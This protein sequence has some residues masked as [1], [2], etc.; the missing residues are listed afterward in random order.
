MKR[1]S[2]LAAVAVAAVGLLA[3]KAVLAQTGYKFKVVT[4][5]KEYGG[6]QFQI[7]DL[8]NKDQFSW[9]IVGP[10]KDSGGGGEVTYFWDGST[11]TRIQPSDTKLSD[12]AALI[13]GNMW[14]PQGINDAGKVAYV[15]DTDKS[16]HAIVVWDSATKT[17]TMI[18]NID[19]VVEGG[20]LTS[21]GVALEGRMVAEINNSDQV[22]W[23]EGLDSGNGDPNDAVFLFDPATK[24]ITTVAHNGTALPGGKTI[25]NALFPNINDAGEVVFMANTTDNENF[26]VYQWAAGNITVICAPDTT[27]DGVK[28]ASAKLPR[29]ANGGLV[30]F[31]GETTPSGSGAPQATD[32]GF[33][34]F[35]GGKLTKVVAPGDALPGGKFVATEGNRRAVGIN[36]DGLVAFKAT[37]ENDQTGIFLWKAGTFTPLV[38]SGQTLE[39]SS[40]VDSLVQGVGDMDG[41]HLAINDFGDVAFSAVIG[42]DHAAV[43][44][45]APR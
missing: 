9:N 10:D 23:S 14:T 1:W 5:S 6:H 43:L 39:S 2:S 20:K 3:P 22:V 12:G 4:T 41:Y 44:A 7:G 27:V 29:N 26:G 8:N 35:A 17:Y 32:T 31:R 42:G 40:K 21:A 34:V 13:S 28:I 45:L 16:P 36:K 15:A 33:F 25:L 18:S 37:M 38:T 19:T 30:V 11:I 24:K